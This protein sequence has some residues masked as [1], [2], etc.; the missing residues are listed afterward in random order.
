MQQAETIGHVRG[1]QETDAFQQVHRREAELGQVA[2]RLL[3]LAAAARRQL[4]PQPEP[5]THVQ[6][7][8][9]FQQPP[10]FGQTLHDQEDALADLLAEQGEPQIR[11]VLHAVAD[12]GRTRI[13]GQRQRDCQFGLAAD[14]Q[15]HAGRVAQ[16]QH[17]VHDFLLL[18]DLDRIRGHVRRAVVELVDGVLK[19]R[20]QPFQLAADDLRKA[21]HDRRGNT[22]LRQRVDDGLERGGRLRLSGEGAHD[23][24][25]CIDREVFAAPVA[26]AVQSGRFFEHG[27]DGRNLR[28]GL[29]RGSVPPVPRRAGIGLFEDAARRRGHVGLAHLHGGKRTVD[30]DLNSLER[31]GRA[32]LMNFTFR[33]KTHANGE[34]FCIPRAPSPAD[35]VRGRL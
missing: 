1:L 3:P 20:A 33:V 28:F 24:A 35:R 34:C 19:R 5:R 12:D 31:G 23:F 9:H 30:G 15:P 14:L 7:L 25:R 16:A 13:A 2:A 17:V 6:A 21:Q 27:L 8:R 29:P 26:D 4:Q 32:T 10:Q 11:P 18:I 22:A